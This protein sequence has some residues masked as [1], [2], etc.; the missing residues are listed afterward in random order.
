MTADETLDATGKYVIPGGIDV[1]THMELPFGGTFAKDTFESGTRAAAFG[2]TT[3]IV[4]FAV[5]SRGASLREGLDAW[6]AKA[7]GNAVADYG[8]H[9][10]MSDVN[11]ETL[12]EMD[13]LVAE[14]VP[15]FKLFTA[16]PGVFYSD[17]GAI[18]RAMQQ[19]AK[20][21]GLIMMHAENGMAIDVVA[22]QT[23]AAG[24]TDP[25]GHGLARKAVFEGEATNRVIRLA[26]AAGVPVYIVHLSA[27]EALAEVRAARDRGAMAF[28]ETCPQ[29]LFL[30]LDDLGQRLQRR[31][32]RVLAAAAPQGPLGGHSGRASS[33]TTCR[34]SSTDHCP[35]DFHGQKELGEGDFRKIPNGLPGV[36]DRLDLLHDG[37]VVAG[38]IS[39]ERWVEIVSTAPAT[40]FGMY[41]RKGAVA[42]G[43]D[44][45]LVI[46]DPAR[47]HRI[48]ATTHHMDVDY[49]CYEGR[50]VQG[51]SDVVLTPGLGH[52]P[53]RRRSPGARATAASSS[54]PPPT[55]PG[56]PDRR[57]ERGRATAGSS[58]ST[59]GSRPSSR[60]AARDL[61][62]RLWSARILLT[63]P[64]AIEDVHLDYFRAGARS[65]RRRATRRPCRVSRRP[66]ST[67]A[68]A[69]APSARA[70]R[71]PGR[72]RERSVAR[73]G[74]MRPR[75]C[76]SPGRSGR[77]ARCWPTAR[78]TA[79]T[80]TPARRSCATSMLRG[81]RHCSRRASTSLAFETIPTVR[82]AE[83]LVALLDAFDASAWLSYACRDGSST[84]AGEPVAAAMVLG[85]HPRSIAPWASTARRRVS[86]PPSW[87]A[88][89]IRDRDAAHRLPEPR[90]P[91]GRE[92]AAVGR[93]RRGWT[94]RRGHR[95]VVVGPR[96]DLAR[97]LLRNRP[98][99][100]RPPRRAA[101]ATL[102]GGPQLA[103][104]GPDPHDAHR[105]V[106]GHERGRASRDVRV[107]GSDSGC[108]PERSVRPSP[109]AGRR[110]GSR[111]G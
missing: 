47:K 77:T 49:S 103:G 82:E 34:S 42:I 15:D 62:D 87:R 99:G 71:W 55:T 41:P 16:Y 70:W 80:T 74:P 108:V 20:N 10:I 7:E 79:A 73:D 105:Q 58:S 64:D 24:T 63:D 6:H 4:D 36:E 25:I 5:Q 60:H 18:F 61:S 46:Y 93:G 96:G 101:R 48:S 31:Q 97:W 66:G 40:L 95:R 43:S 23:V 109:G 83:V 3:S 104:P 111:P 89:A 107:R 35:F 26:E 52:R 56:W 19:T 106:P 21:G 28:A 53:R 29:Y 12:A 65:P 84:A 92:R 68:A 27:R 102:R 38:R 85:D 110:S 86:C 72:A 2:G 37:G 78:S 98:R 51:G 14:G 54:A 33:R 45:D 69:L 9:M 75:S 94:V 1:H 81:S 44:A 22:A 59:A 91:V 8:F 100:H 11:D 90:R 17:D 88:A 30:S 39:R 57:M 13:G 76:S 67:G 32:V 50:T